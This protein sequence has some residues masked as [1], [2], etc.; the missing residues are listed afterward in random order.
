MRQSSI[1]TILFSTCV[2]IFALAGCYRAGGNSASEP[3]G[4]AD[5][6]TDADADSDADTDAD[7]G[8]CDWTTAFDP[9]AELEM[10]GA[11]DVVA[12][13]DLDGDGLADLVGQQYDEAPALKSDSDGPDIVTAFLMFGVAGEEGPF[14]SAVESPVSGWISDIADIDR[15]GVSDLVTNDWNADSVHVYWGSCDGSFTAGPSTS[16]ETD[17]QEIPIAGDFDGD[18]LLDLAIPRAE[19]ESSFLAVLRGNGS[20]GIGDGTFAETSSSPISATAIFDFTIG[21][22]DAD[23][24]DDIALRGYTDDLDAVW[25]LYGNTSIDSEGGALTESLVYSAAES[26]ELANLAAADFDGDGRLDLAIAD[27]AGDTVRL[28]LNEGVGTDGT[29]EFS[30]ASSLLLPVAVA[31]HSV[32]P[33]L[34]QGNALSPVDADGDGA[35]DLYV[36]ATFSVSVMHNLGED[37]S[38]ETLFARPADYA[39]GFTAYQ[40]FVGDFDGDGAIDVVATDG[41]EY[42]AEPYPGY[43]IRGR[44]DTGD[45]S[46]PALEAPWAYPAAAAVGDLDGDGLDDLASLRDTVDDTD[47]R[48]TAFDV[49]LSDGSGGAQMFFDSALYDIGFPVDDGP[50]QPVGDLNG[51][52][53]DDLLVVYG[54]SYAV[55]ASDGAG[56]FAVHTGLAALTR[57]ESLAAAGDFDGDAVADLALVSGYDS[58]PDTDDFAWELLSGAGDGTFGAPAV[59]SMEI[60]GTSVAAGDFDGDGL[61]D[62]AVLGFADTESGAANALE[63]MM[64]TGGSFAE[65]PVEATATS[66]CAL[67]FRHPWLAAADLDGDGADDLVATTARCADGEGDA[68]YVA[69]FLSNGDGS[70]AAPAL[71]GSAATAFVGGAIAD[72]DRDG[73]PDIAAGLHGAGHEFT[74]L[75]GTGYGAFD[76]FEEFGFG[77]STLLSAGDFDGDGVLDVIAGTSDRVSRI[78]LGRCAE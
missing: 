27:D 34:G 44:I 49:R 33:F 25:L 21:D 36:T 18:G 43:L 47:S 64:S 78:H 54:T 75:Y 19:G 52:G 59:V 39:F 55:L 67:E 57:A 35:M 71:Y 76:S 58:S 42:D 38:S 70:F 53:V 40:S 4:G 6:D 14:S 66:G 60:T 9:F 17:Y 11:T 10:E 5:T 24:F 32:R 73:N 20:G 16:L 15:D 22:F 50:P 12:S 56:G 8:P 3:D 29:A 30:A 46:S 45:A 65:L 68:D 74:I 26:E 31:A 77:Y 41:D 23:G 48:Y 28:L 37:A 72:F 51:D 13:L 62:L 63:V 7:D 2:S 69:V 61:D 1:S